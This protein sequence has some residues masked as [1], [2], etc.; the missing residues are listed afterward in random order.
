MLLEW[1]K[2][3]SAQ[4]DETGSTPLHLAA[5]LSRQGQPPNSSYSTQFHGDLHE[6]R[7]S[8]QTIATQTR[9]TLKSLFGPQGQP[10][11][12]CLQLLDANPAVLYEPDHHGSYPIHIA[13]SVGATKT[14]VLFLKKYPNSAGLRDA[15]GRTFLHIAVEKTAVGILYHATRDKSLAWILNM[16]DKDGNTAMHLAVQ[17]GRL[18]TFCR[19][20]GNRK[21]LLN[22]PNAE[23]ETCL[24]LSRYKVP[25]GLYYSQV[26]YHS[27]PSFLTTFR[28]CHWYN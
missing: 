28:H 4:K 24:D 25:P 9:R 19:L 10:K 26:I 2:A 27:T 11:D 18:R 21:I 16:R 12:V 5:A 23:G 7:K 14:V 17:G 8:H 22:L 1:K 3:L 13:T 6:W 15:R 20:L